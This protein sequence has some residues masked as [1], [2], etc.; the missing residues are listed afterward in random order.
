MEVLKSYSQLVDKTKK[1]LSFDISEV[2]FLDEMKATELE[3]IAKSCKIC[4][5]IKEL[6]SLSELVFQLNNFGFALVNYV[7]IFLHLEKYEE[8]MEFI[9]KMYASHVFGQNYVSKQKQYNANERLFDRFIETVNLGKIP[10]KLYLP[11]I[12]KAIFDDKSKLYIY[13]DIAMEYMQTFLRENSDNED[14]FSQNEQLELEYLSLVLEFNTQKG[15]SIIFNNKNHTKIGEQN[16]N[17][18]L[19]AYILDT[20]AFFDKNLPTEFEQRFHYIKVLSAITNNSSV[21]T[22]LDTIY[23]TEQNEEIKTFLAKRLGITEVLNFGT[24]KHFKVLS[25]KK[26]SDIQQRSLG[27]AFENLPLMF[28]DGTYAN[29]QEKTYLIDIFKQENNL[30]NLYS[31]TSLYQIFEKN[32]LHNFAEKLFDKLSQKDDINSA[33]WCVR[34]FSLFS[35]ELFE[36]KIFEFLFSLYKFNRKKEALY[37]TNCLIYSKKPNF[38]E[39]FTRLRVFDL[40]NSHFDEFVKSYSQMIDVDVEEIKDLTLPNSLPDEQIES[41]KQ[42]LYQNFI[43]GRKYSK[44]LFKKLFIQHPIFNEFAQRLVFGE[45]KQGK[46]YSIFLVSGKETMYIYGNNL[47]NSD[48]DVYV[49]LVH[50]LDLDERFDKVNLKLSNPLFEQFSQTKFDVKKFNMSNLYVGNLSGTIV[51]GEKFFEKLKAKGFYPNKKDDEVLFDSITCKNEIL[52]ILVELELQKP[53]SVISPDVVLGNIRFYRLSDCMQDEKKY[54]TNKSQ[55]LS[56]AGINDR[57]FDF[58]MNIVNTK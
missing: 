41:E 23:E 29:D 34:M 57:Y 27:V 55:S 12:L 15:I 54:I 50:S 4:D 31:L 6:Y 22:R 48:K 20:L 28:I 21:E 2:P 13:H 32:S 42:R 40:F 51:E 11:L 45:Y 56:L 5:D 36:R 47:G 58:I 16:A 25:Q 9:S 53:V 17:Q 43:S 39:M 10:S 33:K 30:L 38:M 24:Q 14:I 8:V 1:V 26:V 37:L 46:I 49:S 52:D 7:T 44:L 35:C 19:K 18:F 3:E